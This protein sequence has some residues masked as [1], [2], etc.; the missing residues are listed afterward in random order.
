MG[1]QVCTYSDGNAILWGT[2]NRISEER[3]MALPFALPGLVALKSA[4][5]KLAAAAG[6]TAVRRAALGTAAKGL[7]RA[8]GQRALQA[9]LT[10]GEIAKSALIDT[11]YGGFFAATTPGDVGD[12]GIQLVSDSALALLP[13][14]GGRLA[15][16]KRALNKQGGLSV[17]AQLAEYGGPMPAFAVGQPLITDP[18]LRAKDKIGGGYGETPYERMD[19]E[20]YEDLLRK[21]Q[22]K[23]P[24]IT[25]EDLLGGGFA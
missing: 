11:A 2:Y 23:Y 10:K 13:G 3:I 9:G 5:G 19:R 20:Y 17:A 14:I 21:L 4:L 18:L 8:A 22:Q 7:K 24:G 1:Q 25:M 15:L 12:K 6:A 16:G